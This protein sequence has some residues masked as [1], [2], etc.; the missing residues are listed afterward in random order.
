MLLKAA[1]KR[2]LKRGEAV[3]DDAMEIEVAYLVYGREHAHKMHLD[4]YYKIRS[5][6]NTMHG[7]ILAYPEGLPGGWCK[8][9]KAHFIGHS[10]GAQTVR[11]L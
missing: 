6:R 7:K 9:R 11:Y 2:I 4:T 8:H 1:K 10:M 3:T 5:L